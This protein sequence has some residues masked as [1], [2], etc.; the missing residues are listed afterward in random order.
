MTC[1]GWSCRGLAAAM[2]S[3]ELCDLV[4]SHKLTILFLME[5]RARKGRA[6]RVKS[7]FRFQNFFCVEANG[8]A[9]GLALYGV[10]TLRS[11]F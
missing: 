4:S 2:T 11:K 1:I 8:T 9:R 5:T 6:E 10:I 3:R 7:R